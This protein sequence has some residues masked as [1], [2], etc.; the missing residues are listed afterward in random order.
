M[1]SGKTDIKCQTSGPTKTYVQ[2]SETHGFESTK[3]RVKYRTGWKK[4]NVHVKQ[5]LHM[6]LLTLVCIMFGLFWCSFAI[7]MIFMYSHFLH[8][9]PFVSTPTDCTSH[10]KGAPEGCTYKCSPE[11]P[12]GCGTRNCTRQHI[13]RGPLVAVPREPLVAETGKIFWQIIQ[14]HPFL[15]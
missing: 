9:V 3:K 11:A 8:H 5:W 6:N 12:A 10:C 2:F 13:D 1:G 4:V 15:G 7:T 14:N